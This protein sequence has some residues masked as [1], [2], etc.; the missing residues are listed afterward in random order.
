MS[1]VVDTARASGLNDIVVVVPQ[2]SQG[3]RDVLGSGIH[4]AE[5]QEPLGSGHALLQAQSALQDAE[6]V[7]VLYA[8]G[9]LILPRTLSKIIQLHDESKA[10]IT[11]LT[12][13]HAKPDGLGRVV[14]SPSGRVVEIVEESDADEATLA[15]SEINGG[16]YCFRAPWL[17]DNLGGLEPSPRGEVYLTDLINVGSRQ[18]RPIESV[19]SEDPRETL[20]VNTRVHLAKAE[21]V[22]RQRIRERWMLHGVTIPDPS[23]VYID[24]S[25]EL[26][27][28]TAVLPNT[29]I[30]GGSRV[31]RNCEIG[32]NSIVSESVIGNDCKIISSV[33]EGST[34]EESVNVGPF[35]RIRVDS[36]LESGVHIG[37]FA[38]VKNSR[39]GP[40]T[41]SGHFSYIGD[42]DLG[43]NVNIGAG[44]VT[45]NYDGEKK[46][47]TTIGDDAFIG[48]GSM[49][50][51]P[52]NI[53]AR[54]STGA[55]A[56]VTKDVPPDSLAVGAPAKIQPKKS[57]SVMHRA[58]APSPDVC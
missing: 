41:K 14:R 43:A 1:L 4:Y 28:D 53:G 20:F 35:S 25:V 48:S 23:S 45:C 52:I 17:W 54:S 37:N 9:P 58:D 50:V 5:Q 12:A 6:N 21:A 42:A 30:T 15:I 49:L 26:G 10:C 22:M 33:I 34:L 19:E 24:A 13:T 18:G 55:G 16:T 56:V 2:D 3:I 40:G 7:V 31:G 44:T 51:A 57:R 46:N 32:P 47:P 36:R 29:H 11:M 38:E 8:D 39:L 27:Q